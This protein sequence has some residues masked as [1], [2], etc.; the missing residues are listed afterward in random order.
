MSHKSLGT[1][2]TDSWS[3]FQKHLAVFIAG[4]VIFGL[5][6]GYLAHTMQKTGKEISTSM[7]NSMGVNGMPSQEKMQK[8]AELTMKAMQGNDAAKVE[9]EA[10]GNQME[11]M[12]NQIEEHMDDGTGPTPAMTGKFAGIM[13]KGFLLSMLISILAATYFLS[14]AVFGLADIGSVINK[15]VSNVLPILGLWIWI[16][17][18]TF[19]W[20]P[21]IG[22]VT[23]IILGPR[24]IAA[25]LHLLEGK[26]S[27]F[28]SASM[29]YSETKGKWG[30]IFGNMLV[31]GIVVWIA[32]A[33]I[34]VVL[35]SFG[36]TGGILLAMLVQLGTAF[37]MVFGIQL[38]RTVTK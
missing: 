27:I 4:A 37:L 16:F 38:A 36:T 15:T 20:I 33:I 8:M 1:L 6:G 17:I 14:I 13:G 25:P 23:S 32:I 11:A 9:L 18:R 22:I 2:L 29:S 3:F 31:A 34:G 19:A 5:I 28:D 12:A 26:K 10:M 30:K 24:F 7:M 35:T 21:V